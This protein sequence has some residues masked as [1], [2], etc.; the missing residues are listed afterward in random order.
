M[1]CFRSV[2][3][4]NPI[5]GP[6]RSRSAATTQISSRPLPWRTRGAPSANRK[7][8]WPAR[9]GGAARALRSRSCGARRWT[10]CGRTVR[11]RRLGSA[12]TSCAGRAR[13]QGREAIEG[14]A[15]A[16]SA[17]VRLA[18]GDGAGAAEALARADAV[19]RRQGADSVWHLLAAYAV[20]HAH[21]EGLPLPGPARRGP[22][23]SSARRVRTGRRDRRGAVGGGVRLFGSAARDDAPGRARACD[24]RGGSVRSGPP[25]PRPRDPRRLGR[26]I[27]GSGAGP[28][29]PAR[30]LGV[31][32]RLAPVHDGPRAGAAAGA[33]GSEAG[34]G[35]GVRRRPLARSSRRR[36]DRDLRRGGLR[37]PLGGAG[38]RRRRA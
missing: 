36:R 2:C 35:R 27:A 8:W 30:S 21:D 16:L 22:D 4:A 34:R 1:V 38:I 7:R 37:C 24:R 26:P 15:R 12:W 5:P 33:A 10:R 23:R 11:S 3:G 6:S 9:C 18:A 19:R 14:D 25:R 29:R 31:L 13:Q 32:R 20:H 28:G 17:V